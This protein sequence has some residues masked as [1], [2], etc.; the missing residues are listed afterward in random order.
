MFGQPLFLRFGADYVLQNNVNWNWRLNFGK[1]YTMTQ[2]I[3]FKPSENIKVSFS[4]RG[5]ALKAFTDLKN[6]NYSW[7]WAIEFNV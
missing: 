2:Q 3:D 6:V 7:G 4:D 1:D 5:D